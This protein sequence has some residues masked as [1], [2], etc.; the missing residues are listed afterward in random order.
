MNAPKC[1]I[2]TREPLLGWALL[3]FLLQEMGFEDGAVAD[4]APLALVAQRD[5]KPDLMVL[6]GDTG[7]GD[8]ARL[9]RELRRQRHGQAVLIF[10]GALDAETARRAL[11]AGA[12]GWLTRVDG[13]DELRSAVSAVLRGDLHLSR[14]AADGL[15]SIFTPQMPRGGQAGSRTLAGLSGR[16]HEVLKLMG[17]GLRCKEIASA[18]GISPKTVETHQKRMREKLE[19]RSSVELARLAP[20]AKNGRKR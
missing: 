14:H 13:L 5:R 20:P 15:S 3:R 6:A 7:S 17:S 4:S 19:V 18:L 2:V 9:V 16:E 1:L 10:D 12:R 11:D 8:P